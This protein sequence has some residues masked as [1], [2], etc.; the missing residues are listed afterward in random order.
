MRVSRRRLILEALKE[1]PKRWFELERE[2]VKSGKMGLATL[3]KHLRDLE[4]EKIVIKIVDSSKKPPTTLYQLTRVQTEDERKLT[5]LVK[6]L[7]DFELF[8]N[9]EIEEVMEW[10]IAKFGRAV[11]EALL[12]KVLKDAGWRKPQEQDYV[13]ARWKRAKFLI[14]ASYLKYL[15]NSE[16]VKN[17]SKEDIKKAKH[18]LTSHPELI[19]EMW[20]DNDS[21]KLYMVWKDDVWK[22]NLVEV[23]ATA[24]HEI[25]IRL[26]GGDVHVGIKEGSGRLYNCSPMEGICGNKFFCAAN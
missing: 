25:I 15:P 2:L 9:P 14:L 6:Q 4:R 24:I 18:F 5:K 1:R 17:A 16:E 22:S 8:R 13:E 23:V 12:F 3:S 7:R 19:P 11:D 10:A 20:R 21:G 26:P